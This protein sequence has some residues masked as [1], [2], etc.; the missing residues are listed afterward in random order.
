[1]TISSA[2]EGGTLINGATYLATLDVG[3]VDAWTFWADTGENILV[4]A[5]ETATGNL[6]PWLR[7]FGPDGVLLSTDFNAA[8]AEVVTRATNSG[9]FTVIIGDGSN[10]RGQ[11][12]N[13]RLSLAKAGSPM[14]VSPGDEGGPMSGA[15]VYEGSIDTGDVDAWTFSALQGDIISFQ[16][17]ELVSGSGLTPWVRL[18]GWDGRLLST[19]FHAS[20]VQLVDFVTPAHGTYT[21]VVADG[22]NGLGGSGTYRLTVNGLI[23]QLRLSLPSNADN[24]SVTGIGGEARAPFT[25][26]MSPQFDAPLN[27]WS[28]LVTG[29]FDVFGVITLTNLISPDDPQR[30]FMLERQ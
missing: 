22:N 8:A 3:D 25:L 29:Q 4:R 28:P 19:L 27:S 10:A 9:V 12:G 14:V 2:D 21:L 23:D 18:Y 20:S 26:W 1:M 30:F 5:G 15:D 7:L 6:V 11:T 24:G 17:T 16:V 13:Y